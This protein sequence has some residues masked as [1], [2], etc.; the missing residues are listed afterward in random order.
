MSF[1]EVRISVYR[2][3]ICHCVLLSTRNLAPRQM[4]FAPW[5]MYVSGPG[6]INWPLSA[7]PVDLPNLVITVPADGLAP[8]GARPSAGPAMITK[9][10][11]TLTVLLPFMILNTSR[12]HYSKW[13]TRSG[14]ISRHLEGRSGRSQRAMKNLNGSPRVRNPRCLSSELE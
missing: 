2:V 6:G 12:R 10:R 5:R 9:L 14:E 13:P 3:R 1:L 8:N 7:G 11:Y 4:F